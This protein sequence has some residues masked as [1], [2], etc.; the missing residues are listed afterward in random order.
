MEALRKAWERGWRDVNWMRR[1]PCLASLHGTE[2][3]ERLY[4]ADA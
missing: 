1:D 4:P 3:F 2:E